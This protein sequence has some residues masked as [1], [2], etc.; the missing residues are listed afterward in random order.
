M[1][2]P[3]KVILIYKW[4]PPF[5]R[6]T[7]T[8]KIVSRAFDAHGAMARQFKFVVGH[9]HL[10][11]YIDE[12]QIRNCQG[13]NKCP[14]LS[15]HCHIGKIGHMATAFLL[16][17]FLNPSKVSEVLPS[18]ADVNIDHANYE[19]SCGVETDA[20]RI[21]KEVTTT[22]SKEWRAPLGTWTLELPLH[23]PGR[24]VDG[25]RMGNPHPVGAE[26]PV[27]SD[28]QRATS[29]YMCDNANEVGS[30]SV[31]ASLEPLRNA[32]VVLLT[33]RN[34]DL[35]D[36]DSFQVRLNGSSERT[37]GVL[38]PVRVKRSADIQEE[39]RCHFSCPWSHSADVYV[40]VFDEPQ[41]AVHSM[42]LCT[43]TIPIP[44]PKV[45]SVVFW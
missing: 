8:Q 13:N 36:T 30:F 19:W 15:D 33:F 24:L 22:A 5:H 23:A 31:V 16:L 45:Q 4:D 40:Y 1:T 43:P 34:H 42:E 20:K 21:L 27:R 32:R 7:A 9:V 41:A 18:T 37:K 44:K 28:R 26:D 25:P 2:N 14:I 3:P 29:I 35:M 11:A 12:L 10:A 6:D 39:W 38:V 17:N